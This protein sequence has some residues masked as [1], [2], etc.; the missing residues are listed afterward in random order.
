MLLEDHLFYDRYEHSLFRCKSTHSTNHKVYS[1]LLS[2]LE[3]FSPHGPQR[4]P[5]ESSKS[6][7][8]QSWR[9]ILPQ[10]MQV[11]FPKFVVNRPTAL[12]LA[13][14]SS[15]LMPADKRTTLTAFPSVSSCLL[16]FFIVQVYVLLAD[17]VLFF[18]CIF[19]LF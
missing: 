9:P 4:N 17:C 18:N 5:Q 6:V 1:W 11:S 2:L 13:A 14:N 19:L 8:C 12:A 16:S 7:T 3:S 10:A 15:K